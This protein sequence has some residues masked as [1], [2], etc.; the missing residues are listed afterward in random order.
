M[1]HHHEP[2]IYSRN[3]IFKLN[4]IPYQCFSKACSAEIKKTQEQ[5]NFLY[6][7][8]GADHARDL[9]NRCSIILTDNPFNGNVI[10]WYDTKKSETPRR[11]SNTQT[12][13]FHTGVLD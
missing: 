12:R 11:I 5:S 10:D 7:Y 3:N 4:D 9:S 2:I 8:C 1:H 6:T 13:A